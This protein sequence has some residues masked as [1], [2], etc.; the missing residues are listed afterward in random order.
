M[1]KCNAISQSYFGYY[2][3]HCYSVAWHETDYKVDCVISVCLCV[4]ALRVSFSRFLV[5]IAMQLKWYRRH[6][7]CQCAMM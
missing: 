5:K 1:T 6:M 7:F 3:S 2:P 4:C